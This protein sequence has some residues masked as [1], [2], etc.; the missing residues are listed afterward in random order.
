MYFGNYVFLEGKF[1]IK[2]DNKKNHISSMDFLL[3]YVNQ[4]TG[5]LTEF[6]D[7]KIGEFPVRAGASIGNDYFSFILGLYPHSIGSGITGN[8]LVGDNFMYQE[9]S[10]LSLISNYFTY[11]IS[12]T[13]FDQM[14]NIGGGYGTM[15]RSEF[16][17]MQ[18]FRVV[19]RFD[20]NLFNKVRFAMDLATIYNSHYGFDMR[21][22]YPFVISHNYY[23]Y[24]NELTKRY[25]DE[26]NNLL[27]LYL[28][29]I[30]ISGLALNLE[31]VLDQMQV[32]TENPE[33]IPN[34]WGFLANAKYSFDG[35]NDGMF[36]LWGEFVYTNPY[37]YLNGKR[38]ENGAI[39]YNLDYIVGYRSSGVA[40]YGYSGY[41][42]GPDTILLGVGSEYNSS[43]YV[44]SIGFK[45]V[46]RISGQ[47]RLGNSDGNTIDMGNSIIED[48]SSIFMNAITPTGGWG[49]AE[50]LLQPVI[51]SS[52]T[53]D[54]YNLEVYVSTAFSTYFNYDFH[55]GET[56]FLPQFTIGVRWTGIN[57]DWF[58]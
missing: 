10:N 23:N 20:V 57:N 26:A 36:D 47:K 46:Y 13:R 45:T 11:N 14:D 44:W 12:I 34:A 21:F 42:F 29:I 1:G 32:I 40:D 37:L 54:Y 24:T 2:N 5:Y 56:R 53:W 51:Y 41:Q 18:Q 9:I 30:P 38:E 4:F 17:G 55:K 22:F 52:Y 31:F 19:H 39:D 16:D 48:D 50:H 15:S 58:K 43:D 33:N 28:E 7:V 3:G 8:L 25:F 27:G 49:N 6:A 35:P